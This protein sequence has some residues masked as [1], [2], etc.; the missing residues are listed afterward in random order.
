MQI[1]RRNMFMYLLGSCIDIY[2]RSVCS[3]C[4]ECKKADCLCIESQ[5]RQSDTWTFD[6]GGVFGSPLKVTTCVLGLYVSF[7]AGFGW[8]E[9]GDKVVGILNGQV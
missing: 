9:V 2:I 6:W 5:T 3:V 4:S 7:R 8:L 1:L